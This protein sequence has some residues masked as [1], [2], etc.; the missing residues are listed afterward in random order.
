MERNLCFQ[1][2]GSLGK[3]V[4]LAFETPSGLGWAFPRDDSAPLTT[5]KDHT[6]SLGCLPICDT[7]TP[8]PGGIRQLQVSGRA[9]HAYAWV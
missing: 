8:L 7:S 1:R 6:E 3:S 4:Q 9:L 5:K 2:P